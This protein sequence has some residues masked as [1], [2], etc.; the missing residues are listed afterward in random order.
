MPEEED[1]QLLAVC[2]PFEGGDP[3]V[4][5]AGV[6]SVVVP[7]STGKKLDMVLRFTDVVCL[8]VW[9]GGRGGSELGTT[10]MKKQS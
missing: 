5:S 2:L 6:V 8:V 9:R 3:R 1:E 10:M 4:T 7:T